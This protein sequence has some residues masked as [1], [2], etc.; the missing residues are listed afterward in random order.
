MALDLIYDRTAEDAEQWHYLSTKLDT[1]GWNSLT[2][3]EQQQ[4]LTQLKGGYNH[5]DMN[6]V[7][8]AVAYLGKRFTD[9][10]LHLVAYR[11][12]FN[13][14][15]DPLFQMPYV[16][17]DV[18]I[19]PKTDWALGDPVWVDQAVRYLADLSVLRGLLPLYA[20]APAVPPDLVDLTMEEAND[21]EKLL[22]DIDAEITATALRVEKWIRDTAAAWMYSGDIY[23]GEV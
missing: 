1:G 12:D 13:V 9:L 18:A 6:R 7:G 19:K 22:F 2:A 16:A 23:S 11:E 10:L 14:A 21:I 17:E 20:G 3:E 5:T 15:D 4:W 8:N